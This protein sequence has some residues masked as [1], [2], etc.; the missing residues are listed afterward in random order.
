[1]LTV[2]VGHGKSA[3]GKGWGPRIDSAARVIRM[4]DNQWQNSEDY[5]VRYD[6]GL[7]EMG[8][9]LAKRFKQ[10]N[11]RH[12]KEGWLASVVSREFTPLPANTAVID[13]SDWNKRAMELGGVGAS[14]RLQFQRGTVAA[15]W[16]LETASRGDKL[17]LVG[18]DNVVAGRAL[19]VHE[20]FP[21]KYVSEP[22]SFHF[23]GYIPNAPR[24]GNHDFTIERPFMTRLARSHGVTLKF[25]Q[26]IWQ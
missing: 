23:K 13:Q 26:H 18:F 16:V 19:P 10:L 5:G 17:I 15:C 12:P 4:W 14:G 9:G 2:I 25:A 21:D 1:M 3:E 11:Q 20:G 22:T 6:L 24:Y 7:F 8:G